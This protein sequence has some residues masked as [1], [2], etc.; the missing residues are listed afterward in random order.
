MIAIA[1]VA[2]Y[3]VARASLALQHKS[4]QR[5][6]L[7]PQAGRRAVNWSLEDF[8]ELCLLSGYSCVLDAA[9]SAKARASVLHAASSSLHYWTESR[10]ES[11]RRGR[12]QLI[13]IARI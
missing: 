4:L 12:D 3:R 5:S 7:A 2:I 1:V 13:Y 8:P 9:G 6:F 11:I 10:V